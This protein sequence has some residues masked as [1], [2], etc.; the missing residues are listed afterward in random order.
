MTIVYEYEIS[1]KLIADYGSINNILQFCCIETAYND[2]M[3]SIRAWLLTKIP[4]G[5]V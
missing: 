5:R 3:V 2:G 4:A 1:D